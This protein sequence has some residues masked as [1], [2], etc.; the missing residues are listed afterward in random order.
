MPAIFNKLGDYHHLQRA[1][2]DPIYE[3]YIRPLLRQ[4]H[5][6]IVILQVIVE[7]FT[8]PNS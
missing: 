4:V 1:E 3:W 6:G 5:A 2:H 7:P 8:L